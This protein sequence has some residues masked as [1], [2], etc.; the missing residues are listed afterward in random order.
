MTRPRWIYVRAAALIGLCLVAAQCNNNNSPTV[1]SRFLSG[2]WTGTLQSISG[3]AT[4]RV[5]ITQIGSSFTGTWSVDATSFAGANGGRL[6]GTVIGSNVSIAL[7]PSDPL[8]CFF[9]VTANVTENTMTGTYTTLNCTVVP[10]GSISL[11]R[12]TITLP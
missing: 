8:N 4:A 12:A 3:P 11:T 9:G 10:S 6:S 1:P 5:T 2:L 7:T